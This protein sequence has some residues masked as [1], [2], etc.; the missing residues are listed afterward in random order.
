M[1]S[2]FKKIL[3]ASC[4][5]CCLAN[6]GAVHAAG[7][8]KDRTGETGAASEISNFFSLYELFMLPYFDLAVFDYTPTRSYFAMWTALQQIIT[9]QSNHETDNLTPI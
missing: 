5:L 2:K 7:K 6:T 9:L 4:L 8:D 1:K 3:V